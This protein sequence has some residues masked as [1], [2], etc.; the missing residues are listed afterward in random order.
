MRLPHPT[1]EGVF[2]DVP[3]DDAAD[4]VAAGWLPP[5]PSP[6]PVEAP[7]KPPRSATTRK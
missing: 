7:P 1:F 5:E 6:E 2:K 3:D 4:W